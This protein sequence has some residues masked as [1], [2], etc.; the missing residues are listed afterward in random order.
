MVL[1]CDTV[2]ECLGHVVLWRRLRSHGPG[3][4]DV[5]QL[6][7]WASGHPKPQHY[8]YLLLK[9][10]I[11]KVPREVWNED[12]LV[13][14][15]VWNHG[16]EGRWCRE[17]PDWLAW[18]C[19]TL[20]TKAWRVSYWWPALLL[21][22]EITL[23]SPCPWIV[24]VLSPPHTDLPLPFSLPFIHFLSLSFSFPWDD[25]L[26]PASGES[27]DRLRLTCS[28]PFTRHESFG[29]AFLRVCSSLDSLNDPLVG[30]S[31]TVSSGLSQ[32]CVMLEQGLNIFP[33]FSVSDWEAVAWL[34]YTQTYTHIHSNINING[35]ATLSYR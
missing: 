34:S 25:F 23:Y 4:V 16:R 7:H 32:V 33:P 10:D 13:L 20:D 18:H 17:G 3:R 22:L 35:F 29:L 9:W 19:Q 31:A 6:L 8:R 5:D 27:W 15:M 12:V 21:L 26:A 28:Q 14:A 30:P 1:V 2:S 11:D 24:P